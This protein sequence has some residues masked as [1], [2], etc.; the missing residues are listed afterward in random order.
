MPLE[1]C[2]P[3]RA[4]GHDVLLADQASRAGGRGERAPAK[5][6]RRAALGALAF[7]VQPPR[8]LAWILLEQVLYCCCF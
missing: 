2:G 5:L 8:G 6:T 4:C 7:L 3:S 1:A